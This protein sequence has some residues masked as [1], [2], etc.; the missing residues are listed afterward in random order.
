MVATFTVLPSTVIGTSRTNNLTIFGPLLLSVESARI[1]PT[2]AITAS[3]TAVQTGLNFMPSPF[4]Q[5]RDGRLPTFEHH[6]KTNDSGYPRRATGRGES[7]DSMSLSSS[8]RD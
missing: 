7:N 4:S 6:T 3:I 2:I 5:E 8:R 1:D